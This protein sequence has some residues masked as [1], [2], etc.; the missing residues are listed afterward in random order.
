VDESG[1]EPDNATSLTPISFALFFKSF[2]CLIHRLIQTNIN[3]TISIAEELRTAMETLS[4]RCILSGVLFG[5]AL[6]AAGVYSPTVIIQQM[7]FEDFHMM[8]AFFSAS[9]TSAYVPPFPWP[10]PPPRSKL[11]A[12]HK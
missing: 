4:P 7:H 9:A 10:S 2:L 6:T 1:K 3:I 8:K 12:Y 11:A 5:A